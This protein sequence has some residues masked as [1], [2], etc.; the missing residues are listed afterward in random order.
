VKIVL[1]ALDREPGRAAQILRAQFPGGAIETLPVTEIE[2]LSAWQ[3]L[4]VLRALK[5]DLFAVSTERLAWQQGQNLLLMFGALGGVREVM[6]FDPFGAER[7]EARGHTLLHAPLRL[8]REEWISWMTVRRARRE[9]R[10]LELEV[11]QKEIDWDS[12]EIHRSAKPRIAYLRTTPAAGTQSG[13]ATTH[14][15][16]F[17]KAAADI[18]ASVSVISN[19]HIAGLDESRVS[20]TLIEP[21]SVGLTRAAFDLRNGML[22][23][24]RALLEIE[25]QSPDF[26]YQRYS[27]F[28]WTGVEASLKTTRPLFLEYNGSELWMA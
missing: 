23:T 11:A 4:R 26:I 19:D 14:T 27:R 16:G 17:I 10:R 18:A 22:F 24:G 20:M 7:R 21:D 12:S 1:L 8:M 13:G 2:N 3:R 28:N 5:P 25:K 6:L 15:I 9:L